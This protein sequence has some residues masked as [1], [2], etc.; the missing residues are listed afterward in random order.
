MHDNRSA[1]DRLRAIVELND[2]VRDIDH[3]AAGGIGGEIS[4]ITHMATGNIVGAC[5]VRPV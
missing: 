5:A 3:H 2:A 4:E 1:S